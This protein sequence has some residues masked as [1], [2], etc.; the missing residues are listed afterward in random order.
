MTRAELETRANRLG[1]VY[2]NSH[3]DAELVELIRAKEN[4]VTQPNTSHPPCFGAYWEGISDSDCQKCDFHK[5]TTCAQRSAR[6]GLDE[7]VNQLRVDGV[8]TTFA[9][10]QALSG[11]RTPDLNYLLTLRAQMPDV[12]PI[13]FEPMQ[14]AS[15]VEEQ[16]EAPV[17]EPA[18]PPPVVEEEEDEPEDDWD[19][20]DGDEDE[21]ELT[22]EDVSEEEPEPEALA[23]PEP[24]PEP[25]PVQKATKKVT[26][27]KAAS[28]KTSKKKTTK[29]VAAKPA[30]SKKKAAK[31]AAKKAT[32]KKVASKKKTASKKAAPK[33]KAA[34]SGNPRTAGSASSAAGTAKTQTKRA[35]NAKTVAE[36]ALLLTPG[37]VQWALRHEKEKRNNP[38]IAALTPGMVLERLI[39][40]GPN[41]GKTIKVKVL[42]GKYRAR[43]D[44]QQQDF[45][46]LYASQLWAEPGI[47]VPG[48]LKADGTRGKPRYTAKW[49]T[50]KYFRLKSKLPNV[51][52][53]KSKRKTKK[54]ASPTTSKKKA[55]PKKAE[56]KAKVTSIRGAK[57]RKKKTTKKLRRQA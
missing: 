33:K 19:E 13:G 26:K 6:E 25:A 46:T 21:D 42:T 8:V 24:E 7:F 11:T 45:P 48:Q 20:D 51:T 1:I 44:N 5:D 18:A 12:E 38:Y 32:S 3:S 56:T 55:A 35:K 4:P 10:L 16:T 29:K 14:P 23:Q 28:K 57:S 31:P 22:E 53:S 43:V 47:T 36:Q 54:K 27:K 17:E 50:T 49:S 39:Q 41:A 52:P 15:T 34:G 40:S 37:S 9:S 30:A 2:L